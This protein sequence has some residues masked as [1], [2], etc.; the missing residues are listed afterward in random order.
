MAYYVSGQLSDDCTKVVLD[1][2]QIMYP[3]LKD[4]VGE[5][6][7]F[8]L[9]KNYNKRSSKQNRYLHGV[10]LPS[11]INFIKAT[12]GTVYTKDKIKAFIYT[13]ILEYSVESITVMGRECFNVVGKHFSEMTTKE[14]GEAVE[15]VREHFAQQGLHIPEPTGDNLLNDYYEYDIKKQ[16]Q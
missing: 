14:F 8:P 2:G 1:H 11:I 5:T 12:E 6:L 9:E 4:L 7:V 10:I 3:Y 13:N 16:F 15:I